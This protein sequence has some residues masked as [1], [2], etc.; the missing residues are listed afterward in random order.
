MILVILFKIT[1]AC[2]I[3]YSEKTHTHTHTH[4]DTHSD[5]GVTVMGGTQSRT[6][7]VKCI[8]RHREERNPSRLC[9]FQAIPLGIQSLPCCLLSL[10]TAKSIWPLLWPQGWRSPSVNSLY[11]TGLSGRAWLGAVQSTFFRGAVNVI[12]WWSHLLKSARSHQDRLNVI[13]V[14]STETMQLNTR[15]FQSCTIA[16]VKVKAI[17][18]IFC[19]IK[20]TA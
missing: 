11:K 12:Y 19:N 17:L 10:K 7:S 1:H 18:C 2:R 13:A 16:N 3:D 5:R 20:I 9:L 8:P 4:T 6:E 15:D 14:V